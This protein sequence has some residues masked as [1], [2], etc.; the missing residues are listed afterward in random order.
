MADTFP[1]TGLGIKRARQ[2]LGFTP[3]GG[4]RANID[5]RTGD[6]GSAI[7]RGLI[8]IANRVVSDFVDAR[9]AEERVRKEQLA[10]RDARSTVEGNALITTAIN[11]NIAFRDVSP[12]TTTWGKDFDKRMVKVEQGLGKLPFTTEAR[13]A[14]QV[15]FEAKRSVASSRG[16][17]AEV[18]RDRFDTRRSIIAGVTD[19]VAHGTPKAMSEAVEQYKLAAPSVIIPP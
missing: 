9:E 6:V 17:I 10:M 15:G 7:G 5:V 4:V 19:M 3:F 2:E 18:G 14:M 13:Q 16:L 8:T 1:V 11:E 12:D